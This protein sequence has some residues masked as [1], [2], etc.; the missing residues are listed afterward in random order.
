MLDYLFATI[1]DLLYAEE[2]CFPP[3]PTIE[4]FLVDVPVDEISIQLGIGI[5]T[6]TGPIKGRSEARRELCRKFRAKIEQTE[7][8]DRVKRLLYGWE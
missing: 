8:P 2:D 5:L 7:A 3:W 4:Q 1:D 6:I